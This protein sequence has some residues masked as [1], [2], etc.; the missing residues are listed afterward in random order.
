MHINVSPADERYL[1]EMAARGLYKN[2]EEVVEAALRLLREQE[3]AETRL[4]AALEAGENEIT[5]GLGI[6]YNPEFLDECEKLARENLANGI[7]P[8]PDVCP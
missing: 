8:N 3:N 2:P 7:K 6:P 1:K 5:G 4:I